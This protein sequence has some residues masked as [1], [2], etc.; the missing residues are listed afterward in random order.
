MIAEAD[1]IFLTNERFPKTGNGNAAVTPLEKGGSER[2]FYRIRFGDESMIF[3][4]Y[5]G[6]KEE[7]RHYVDIARF[8]NGAGV[9]VPEIHH[10]DSEEGLIWMQD[11]GEQDLWSFRNASWTP[12]RALYEST[13]EGVLR[14]HAQ[15]TKLANGADLR[16]ERVFDA[17]LYLWE[18]GYFFEN[19]LGNYFQTPESELTELAALP[20]L[21]EATTAL[22]AR[23]RM[24]VHRDFQSQN[25]MIHEGA[26]WLID[27]Q[28][29][30]YGLAQY[31]LASLLYDP[32]VALTSDE[33]CELLA[34]Y[35][36]R[37]EQNGTPVDSD[38]DE[39]FRWCALQR[40]MQAL[41]A[42][43]FLGLKKNRPDF[44]AHTPV[45]LRSLLEVASALDG[46]APL[47]KKLNSLS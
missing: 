32:Y 7:N 21:R 2:K 39:I 37:L 15:A 17:D 34:F 27:F 24:L 44:L 30:R 36:K 35:K 42:Y 43:G 18:Q 20:A 1:V 31:D 8:L 3:V 38:F 11:L 40:L 13:L 41:G 23:P 46:L 45:A 19:C 12:R 5:S 26:A 29:M 25:V 16:L 22:A 9:P 10:H 14:M 33:R 4:K 47:V 28:G 6:H